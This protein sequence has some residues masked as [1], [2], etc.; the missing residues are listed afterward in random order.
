M[1]SVPKCSLCKGT[2]IVEDKLKNK[3]QP[4]LIYSVFFII[5]IEMFSIFL[6]NV[7][8]STEFNKLYLVKIYPMLTQI[9]MFLAVSSIFMWREKLRFCLRKATA[10]MFLSIYYLFGFFAILFCFS[11]SIYYQFV[12]VAL[13]GLVF[14]LFVQSIYAK[15]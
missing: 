2:E 7:N 5:M 14:L 8:I 1:A 4:Y 12:N 6:N 13:I 9:S 15:K 3:K 10:T 11:S